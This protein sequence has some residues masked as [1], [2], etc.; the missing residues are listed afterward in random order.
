MRLLLTI[1]LLCVVRSVAFADYL[2]VRR[3]ALLKENPE[4]E[5]EMVV[6]LEPPMNLQLLDGGQQDNGYYR[7][8]LADGS[9]EGWVYRTFV[10]RRPGNL[11]GT[12]VASSGSGACAVDLASCGDNGCAPLG[13][14]H[15]LM[16]AMKRHDPTGQPL[17]PLTFAQFR[18][19]QRRVED[20][21][22]DMGKGSHLTQEDRDRLKN[23][24]AGNGTTVGEGDFVQ[25]VGFLAEERNIR[26]AGPESVNCRLKGG[27]ANN[28]VHLPWSSGRARRNT[29]ALWWNRF[30][31]TGP[32]R[33]LSRCS[34][35]SNPS[36]GSSW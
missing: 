29:T 36:V 7:A 27:F 5:A 10:R 14:E 35:V 34:S 22:I 32:P 17:V 19:L 2:E 15:A 11:P 12:S 18:T 23:L 13:S 21:G 20:L 33:G 24:N 26:P 31:R 3:T 8:A 16:N 4:R 30:R 25:L 1:A 9:Q 28:D 6:R